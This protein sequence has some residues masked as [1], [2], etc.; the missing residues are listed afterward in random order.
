MTLTWD[1]FLNQ[2]AELFQLYFI[3]SM[4]KC[5]GCSDVL[6]VT[7]YQRSFKPHIGCAYVQICCLVCLPAF[8]QCSVAIQ[9]INAQFT[10]QQNALERIHVLIYC[11]MLLSYVTVYNLFKCVKCT[12]ALSVTQYQYRFIVFVELHCLYQHVPTDFVLCTDRLFFYV[13]VY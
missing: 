3:S 10:R 1:I 8:R 2:S 7:L 4:D 6:F 13:T 11:L 5:T 12:Y 9:V